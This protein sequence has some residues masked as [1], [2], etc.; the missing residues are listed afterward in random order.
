MNRP[1]HII[2]HYSNS[3]FGNAHTIDKWHSERGF[4]FT[5]HDGSTGHIGY[6]YVVGNGVGLDHGAI[7][8]GRPED[9]IGAHAPGYNSRSIGICLIGHPFNHN[10][11]LAAVALTR[12][13]MKKYDIPPA[14]VLGHFETREDVKLCPGLDMRLFREAVS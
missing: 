12:R 13:L 7:E 8:Q 11:I 1:T 5:R 3:H 10:Q 14:Q 9:T 6:H 4:R 2:I